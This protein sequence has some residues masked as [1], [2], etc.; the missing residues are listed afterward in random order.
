VSLAV[1]A[2]TSPRRG[3][4]R[5]RSGSPLRTDRGFRA[6]SSAIPLDVRLIDSPNLDPSLVW[7][8][9]RTP[10]PR[11]R[12]GPFWIDRTPCIVDRSI[13][14]PRRR[15]QI[16]RHCARP[17][18]RDGQPI[19][20]ADIDGRDHVGCVGAARD[21]LRAP[22]DHCVVELAG[23]VACN[24][25]SFWDDSGFLNL[26]AQERHQIYIRDCSP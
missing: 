2:M 8:Q 7:R 4:A 26:G 19:V 17:P 9:T 10:V 14:S 24:R 16:Q 3:P 25:L 15:W 18:E 6:P 23:V 1:S 22:V 20:A 21:K 11:S 12:G 5:R 13:T